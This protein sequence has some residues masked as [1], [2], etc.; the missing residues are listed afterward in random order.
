MRSHRHCLQRS[1]LIISTT[2]T[3][4]IRKVYSI[5]HTIHT[6]STRD[7]F[8]EYNSY[9]LRIIMCLRDINQFRIHIMD[10][11]TQVKGVHSR[12]KK[13]VCTSIPHS[14]FRATPWP[15]A[16]S[17]CARDGGCLLNKIRAAGW[18]ISFKLFYCVQLN[19]ATM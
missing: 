12:D 17:C 6:I 3:I 16:V 4:L 19:Y 10:A 7:N 8:H 5:T 14:D 13:I 2:V 1:L 15:W 9:W 11:F 18:G